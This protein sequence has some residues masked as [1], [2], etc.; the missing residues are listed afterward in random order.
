MSHFAL[1][2]PQH[3]VSLLSWLQCHK[4][5]EELCIVESSTAPQVASVLLP[6]S[7]S[8]EIGRQALS[9]KSYSHSSTV[10]MYDEE[11]RLYLMA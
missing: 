9:G 10:C 11:P 4:W 7:L 5:H 6:I 8:T 2:N 1:Q 3:S